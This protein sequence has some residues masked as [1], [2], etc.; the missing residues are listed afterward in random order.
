VG[1]V[2]LPVVMVV[3]E[4]GRVVQ[5]ALQGGLLMTL[6]VV[7]EFHHLYLAHKFNTLA[8]AAAE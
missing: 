2:N 6:L 7:L 3:A 1:Q 8:A 5:A 4:A